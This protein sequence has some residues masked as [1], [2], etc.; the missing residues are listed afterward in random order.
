MP[1]SRRKQVR[2]KREDTQ[3]P[4]ASTLPAELVTS[5]EGLWNRARS[6]R[7]LTE[8]VLG[9][10][11]G[12]R[13]FGQ[14]MLTRLLEDRDEPYRKE[15][16]V[17]P[18][19]ECGAH[20]VRRTKK[21]LLEVRRSTLLGPVSYR[22][23][24]YQCPHCRTRIFPLDESLSLA[25]ALRGHS[26]EFASA[27][28]L[29]CTI[30]PFGKGCDLFERCHGVSVSTKL[31]QALTLAI[32]LRLFQ[33]ELQRANELWEKRYREPE[34]FEPPPA[35][36]RQLRRHRRVYVMMDNSKIATQEGK[37][38]RKA[39]RDK[40]LRKLAQE[41]ARKAA[42]QKK[43]QRLGPAAA[44]VD[45]LPVGDLK[46][47]EAWRDARALLIFREEDLAQ[48]S[49]KRRQILHR[50]V[51]AHVGTKEEWIRLV[52]LALYEE[53]VYTAH[54]VVIIADGGQ[55]IWEMFE[56]LLPATTSRRVFQ[57]LD[58]YHAASHL[59]AAGR[60]I[61]GCKTEA[62]RKACAA[63]VQPLL[64]DLAEGR[65]ANVIQ[66]LRKLRK[67]T[68]TTAE[69]VHKCA[70][71]FKTH[72]TRMRYSW[73]RKNSLLIGSGPIESVHAW[74]IQPRC[75]LPGMRWSVLGANAM[76]RLRCSWASDRWDEDFASAARAAPFD[77]RKIKE[78]AAAAAP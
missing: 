60:A 45:P 68:G 20:M 3:K 77:R 73:Y 75:R 18:C 50:R 32:G 21:K 2:Q 67:L 69:V 47:D 23:C 76:L 63:W 78:L 57:I 58:W 5:M 4:S 7:R 24:Q 17:V 41:A 72:Q 55:G 59:W 36:L 1:S 48:T 43:Q 44:N 11:T 65:V 53:G 15:L 22:R 56:E 30:V 33:D 66:R 46:T 14:L 74:V 27:L 16:V 71:Y 64:D 25:A 12:L 9:L 52:H 54:E 62:Q 26:E 42:R 8:L 28:V 49:K 10:L 51:I 40:T 29:L 37:R 6:A 31:A 38:G 35:T 70:D 13:M 34:L 19:P 61:K 39:P